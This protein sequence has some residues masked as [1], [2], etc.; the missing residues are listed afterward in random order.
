MVRGL[1]H[2][3]C[4]ERLRELCFFRLEKKRLREVVIP[5]FSYLQEAVERAR[6]F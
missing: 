3:P 2:M 1:E 4:E 5:V 6:F